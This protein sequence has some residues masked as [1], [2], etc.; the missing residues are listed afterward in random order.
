MKSEKK[1]RETIDN[2][3]E[4]AGWVIQ[5]RDE[6]NLGVNVGVAIREL[7]VKGGYSD[8]VLFVDRKAKQNSTITE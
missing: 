1:A 2:M 4:K 5:N 6:I 7:I 8:Y 3:L